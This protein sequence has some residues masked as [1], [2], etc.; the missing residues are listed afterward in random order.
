MRQTGGNNLY[1]PAEAR[2]KDIVNDYASLTGT[3]KW[4]L[5]SIFLLVIR[6]VIQTPAM[7]VRS[8]RKLCQL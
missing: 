2:L 5:A 7:L 4:L 1:P 8:Q 6:P 3:N